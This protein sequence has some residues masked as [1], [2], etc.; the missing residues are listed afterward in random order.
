MP[1]PEIPA[2]SRGL[3]PF[4]RPTPINGSGHPLFWGESFDPRFVG[5][6]LFSARP[7]LRPL[8]PLPA[9]E[10]SGV[11]RGDKWEVSCPFPGCRRSFLSAVARKAHW[12]TEHQSRG[13]S[14]V[15]V[16]GPLKIGTRIFRSEDWW[17]GGRITDVG[18]RQEAMRT[19]GRR[20]WEETVRGYECEKKD[21][22]LFARRIGAR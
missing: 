9:I 17:A 3:L 14:P 2:Y 16:P 7:Y 15:V 19:A 8:P 10:E 13:D 1:L 6:G 20:L 22:A 21:T 5:R 18:G 12:Q 11:L 4:L